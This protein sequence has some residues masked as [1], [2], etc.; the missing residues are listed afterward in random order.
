[1]TS[2]FISHGAPDRIIRDEPASLF[3]QSLPTRREKPSA[4]V[5]LSAHWETEKLT[6]TQS[7]KLA[8]VHDFYGFPPELDEI[9]YIAQ[10]PK[11]LA[12][13]VIEG[14]E[15]NGYSVDM[16]SRGIDH[17]VWTVLAPMYPKADVPVLQVSLPRSPDLN[18]YIDLG[19]ALAGLTTQ[20][21]LVVGS[22][23]ATHNLMRLSHESAPPSWAVDFV[24]WLQ[25]AVIHRQHDQ[26]VNLYSQ[27]PYG[28]L[29]HPTL[30]HY[31]PLLV[32]SGVHF[33]G[34]AELIH[35]SYEYGALN[36]SAFIFEP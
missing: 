19:Q 27:A 33:S 15:N 1:M 7:G 30:E 6:I 21:I 26:L 36:N 3:F 31:V 28:K 9:N 25:N 29:A 23:S 11:W 4:I 34:S 17:G 8:S 12:D 22:G 14:L 18:R 20:N 10:Q 2:V 24:A 35:D 13:K 32:A 16:S 5:I